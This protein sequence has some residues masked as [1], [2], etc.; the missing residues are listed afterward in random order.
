[1][2]EGRTAKDEIFSPVNGNPSPERQRPPDRIREHLARRSTGGIGLRRLP[3]PAADAIPSATLSVVF[4]VLI[5]LF[6]LFL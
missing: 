1:M 4:R 6:P 2:E 5:V 3:S